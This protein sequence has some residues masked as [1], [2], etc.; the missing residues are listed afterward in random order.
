MISALLIGPL[1]VKSVIVVSSASEI[2]L[3]SVP[4]SVRVTV[5]LCALSPSVATSK[6][7]TLR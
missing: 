4:A 5:L 1:I 7:R 2:K 6:R 3:E